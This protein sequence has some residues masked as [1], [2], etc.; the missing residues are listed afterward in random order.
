[1]L[2]GVAFLTLLER[3]VLGYIQLRKGP[4]RVGWAGVP[5]PFADAIKLFTKES[6]YPLVSNFLMYLAAPIT[7]MALALVVWIVLPIK[8][9]LHNFNIGM[10]FF[11]CCTS[12]G[13]YTV[14]ISGWASNSKYSMLGGLRSVAQTI[15]YEVRLALIL[16]SFFILVRSFNINEIISTQSACNFM[17][18][19]PPLALMWFA[20]RLAETNRTPF[21]LAEGESE[22]VSGFNIEY[23]SGGF[24]LIFIAEYARILF[25]RCLTVVIFLGPNNNFWLYALKRAALAFTFVWARGT[26]PRIRYDKLINLAWKRFLPVALN[27]I[28]IFAGLKLIINLIYKFK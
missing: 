22:L 4:N 18:A 16:I 1:M 5:Q 19:A 8:F 7:A 3:R 14:L 6:T 12:L 27:Y 28:V 26:L 23:R 25:I 10:L 11:L 2:I 20:S 24:A 13:V 17:L 21:D 9:G 15:S